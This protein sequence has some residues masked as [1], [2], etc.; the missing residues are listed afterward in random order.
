MPDNSGMRARLGRL[1]LAVLAGL[2]LLAAVLVADSPLHRHDPTAQGRCALCQL[3][4]LGAE[5]ATTLIGL[6]IA[7]LAILLEPLAGQ[8]TP[9]QPLLCSIAGRGPP[10]PSFPAC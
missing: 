6:A 4:H 10:R 8:V 2:L 5:P 1:V 9:D 7:L 3:Q